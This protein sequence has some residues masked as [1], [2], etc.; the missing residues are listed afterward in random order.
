MGGMIAQELVLRH[1][2]RVRGLVLACTYPEPD[3]DV[4]RQ[5]EFS[6]AQFGGT[7]TAAG[8]MRIDVAALNPLPSPAGRRSSR[9]RR[10]ASAGRPRSPWRAAAPTWSSAT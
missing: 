2:E 10:A 1:P 3:A 8:E 5:R 4:E 9:G 6:V 7:V